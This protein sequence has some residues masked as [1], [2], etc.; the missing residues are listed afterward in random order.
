MPVR[1]QQRI[2]LELKDEGAK[3]VF[4]P[5]V[6]ADVANF[7]DKTPQSEILQLVA[8]KIESWDGVEDQEGNPVECNK[9][10]F[11][12]LLPIDVSSK[13]LKNLMEKMGIGEEFAKK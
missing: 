7:S 9:D 4:K 10:N 13:I 11:I 6:L 2:V 12:N 1:V 3:F 5:M 8:G